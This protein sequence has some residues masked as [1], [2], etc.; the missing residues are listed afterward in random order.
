[1]TEVK[2]NAKKFADLMK[3]K[4]FTDGQLAYKSGVSRSM[5]FYMRKGEREKVSGEIVAKL[6]GH[7]GTSIQY[8]MDET[9]DPSPNQKKMSALSADIVTIL[10]ELPLSKQKEFER[11]ARALRDAE[12][13]ATVE[14]IYDE[15]IERI[16]RL[17]ELEGG[18]DALNRLV[19]HL[20]SASERGSGSPG[21]SVPRRKRK[22]SS[23]DKSGSVEDVPTE[24]DS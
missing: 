11:I 5:I 20:N 18:E 19:D 7:L 15:L 4:G 23:K 24:G 9:D 21:P 2:F 10:D 16:T 17:T 13:K 1:M 3:K 8:L 22:G 14:T 12:E 6:A